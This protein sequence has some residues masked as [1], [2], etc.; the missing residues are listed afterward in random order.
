MIADEQYV[1]IAALNQYAYCPHRCWRMF[2]AGGFTDNAAT[3]E[4]SDLHRR[5]H[6]VGSG[7]RD[8]VQQWRGIWL[9][10]EQY[11]LIGKADLIEYRENLYC[12]VEYKRGAQSDWDNDA[13]QLCGQALCLE[14]MT[15]STVP[16]G[17][18]YSTRLHRREA[19]PL[20]GPVRMQTVETI[21]AVREMLTSGA[22][23]P[24][25]YSK[26]CEG[27]SLLEQCRPKLAA[28]VAKYQEEN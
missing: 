22:M 25:I 8:E 6:T 15:G 11:G 17:F 28:K 3:I 2:C 1:P 5:V 27:C 9:R 13:L 14:E 12:P 16:V 23:P 20:V 24:A 21:A 26:R 19:V 10:S 4:G 18:I 7:N